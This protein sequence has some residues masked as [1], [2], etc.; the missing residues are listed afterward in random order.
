[1]HGQSSSAFG[2]AIFGELAL[3]RSPALDKWHSSKAFLWI[4][5]FIDVEYAGSNNEGAIRL[6]ESSPSFI[7]NEILNNQGYAISADSGSFPTVLNNNVHDNSGNGLEIRGG[8]L[9]A[10]GDW[11]NTSIVYSVTGPLTIDGSATLTIHPRVI[12]KFGDNVYFDVYGSLR[13]KGDSENQITLT[14][15]KD[16]L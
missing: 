13:V 2:A 14:S 9:S 16:P 3:G 12:V 4:K 10:S 8:T 1:M 6:N 15:I 7:N 11:K 5:V